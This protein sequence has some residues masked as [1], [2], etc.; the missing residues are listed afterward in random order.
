[1]ARIAVGGFQHETNTFAP[2]PAD[3]AAFAELDA[4]PGLVEGKKI[5][6]AVAGMNIPI[7]GALEL[8]A[9]AG[10]EIV[11]LSWAAAQ[12]SGRVTDDAFERMS[13]ILLDALA[14]AGKIDGLY[15]DLHGAMATDSH[16]DGEAEILRRMRDQIGAEIPIA[17]SLDLHANVSREMIDRADVLAGYRTY[18]HVDMAE[19]G[20]RAARALE[21]LAGT[22][23][24][25][26]KAFRQLDYLIPLVWQSTI[27]QPARALYGRVGSLEA[28]ARGRALPSIC[29][30]FPLADVPDAGPSVIAYGDEAEKACDDLFAAMEAAREHFDG[31]ALAPREAV[32]EALRRA[33][34]ANK[35]VVL[36]DSSDNPGAGA[37]C[38][39]TALLAELIAQKAKG[40]AFGL[41]YDPAAA[42]AAHAAGNGATVSL[43]LG[44]SSLAADDAPVEGRFRIEKLSKGR[45]KATGPFYRGAKMAL[46]PMAALR[47]VDSGVAVLIASRKQQA[48]DQAMFRHLGIDPVAAPV[49]AVKSS[50]HYRADFEP[51]ADGLIVVDGPGA[52]PLDP[53]RLDFKKLRAGVRLGPSGPVHGD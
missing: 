19:T 1:V 51:I 25:P 11:P 12:P 44:G 33:A 14:T 37:T 9:R 43:A 31:A 10:H 24:R 27:D 3:W 50:V 6:R 40:A 29:M 34:E 22:D 36:A 21:A 30:G 8:L 17:V 39:T 2:V 16:D 4:W 52:A 47:E 41:L 28:A 32:A 42:E 5:A 49:L 15:L 23:R 35:P 38:G 53:T 48:A 7:A 20:A 26:A 18:P 45:F 46:G 13:S